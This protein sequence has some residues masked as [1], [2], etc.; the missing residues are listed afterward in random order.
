MKWLCLA[1][2]L[3]VLQTTSPI[4]RQTA[5]SSASTSKKVQKK[6]QQNQAPP[7]SSAP[8]VNTT[9][10]PTHENE[11]NQQGTKNTDNSVVVREFPPV[12][13]NLKRDWVDVSVWLFDGLL[14][15]VGFLQWCVLS[16]QEKLMG[17]HATHLEKLADETENNVS[18]IASQSALLQ[19]SAQRQ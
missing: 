6:T 2:L 8:P 18:A 11:G 17:V 4:P 12:M 14:V 3:T 5:D 15:F 9:T 7:A 10:A 13:V 16:K 1:V 19:D